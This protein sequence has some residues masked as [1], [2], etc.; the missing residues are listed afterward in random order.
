MAPRCTVYHSLL[1][2]RTRQVS[3][4][5]CLRGTR[6][7]VNRVRKLSWPR[8]S[9]PRP[10]T[11]AGPKWLRLLSRCDG[12]EV[13]ASSKE[14]HSLLFPGGSYPTLYQPSLSRSGAAMPGRSAGKKSLLRSQLLRFHKPLSDWVTFFSPSPLSVALLRLLM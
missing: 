9:W 11:S 5:I 4:Q 10:N 3:L 12:P 14:H 1:D 7:R 8:M 13:E 6:T 2:D